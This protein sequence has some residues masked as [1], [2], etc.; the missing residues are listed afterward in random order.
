[1]PTSDWKF[2]PEYPLPSLDTLDVV[3]MSSTV[4]ISVEIKS[5]ISNAYPLDY[6]RGTHQTVKYDALLRAMA[7]CGRDIPS[8]IRSVLVL[9]STMPRQFVEVA[10]QLDVNVFEDTGN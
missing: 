3:F 7:K 1:M 6:E 4:C 2:F 9:Q 5:K 8:D 10:K